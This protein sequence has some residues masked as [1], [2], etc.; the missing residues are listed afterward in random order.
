VLRT[1]LEQCDH[2]GVAA[3]LESSKESNIDFYA[4]HGFRVLDELR[5]L[6]GP[7]MWPMWRDAR[8]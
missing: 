3:Y 1:M 2:D 7:T 8:P 6:R 5:L 4:R